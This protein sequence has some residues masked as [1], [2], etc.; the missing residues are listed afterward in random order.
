MNPMTRPGQDVPSL[1]GD[2]AAGSQVADEPGGLVLRPRGEVAA[3]ERA[4]DRF[5]RSGLDDCVL[6]V[7]ELGPRGSQGVAEEEDGG[8]LV[9]PL[10]RVLNKLFRKASATT[11]GQRGVTTV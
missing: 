8:K 3:P 1:V 7:A 11:H 2:L 9:P 4:V 10:Q 5:I 6:A